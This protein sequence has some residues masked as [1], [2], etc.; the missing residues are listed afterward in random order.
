MAAEK[1]KRASSLRHSVLTAI[2]LAC[3]GASM[4]SPAIG[5]T[6]APS[7]EQAAPV[8]PGP[9]QPGPAINIWPGIAPGSENWKQ[10]EIEHDYRDGGGRIVRNVVT[11]TLT[12]YFPQAG[13]ANGTAVIVAPGGA[14][15]MLAI[16][17]EGRAVARWLAQR[18]ITAFVLKYR[19][20]E[21][22]ADP[23]EFGR[24]DMATSANRATGGNRVPT[25]PNS[26]ALPPR[27]ADASAFGIADGIEAIRLIRQRASEWGIDP[28]RV[29][30]V[31]F[32][33]GGRVAAG[34]LLNTDAAA[35]PS[36]AA[37]I[38]GGVFGA[39]NLK[40]PRDLPPVFL[41]TAIDD[42]AAPTVIQ[43][44]DA[45]RM[46]GGTPELHV[47]SQ[48]GHGFGM[49]QQG[50]TSDNWIQ[51]FYWWM[52]S[53][54]LL[55]ERGAAIIGLDTPLREWLSNPKARAILE[56]YIPGMLDNPAIQSAT[57][58]SIRTLARF[59]PDRLTPAILQAIEADVVALQKK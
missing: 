40:V 38:Y 33:A 46:A 45:L 26:V 41:A 52:E 11:P 2:A 29:G 18:G 21:T 17:N 9:V 14:F 56:R 53:S 32:S 25:A 19:L 39:S 43:L 12:P 20:A 51:G 36:F 16:E 42:F 10:V 23:A 57:S 44:F 55:A 54:G 22:P 37:P 3:V 49:N 58:H 28:A 7:A 13:T 5:Q 24:G 47:F 35:R 50:T 30:I 34:A 4:T 59:A 31:G 1:L 27:S 6:A 8:Q 15:T 48:G